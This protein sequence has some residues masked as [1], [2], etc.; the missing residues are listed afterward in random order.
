MESQNR[1]YRQKRYSFAKKGLRYFWQHKRLALLPTIGRLTYLITI[2]WLLMPLIEKA[3][4]HHGIT[5]KNAI[6]AYH[7]TL[8]LWVFYLIFILLLYINNV[9]ITFAYGLMTAIVVEEQKGNP[10]P[11]RSAWKICAKNF[12]PIMWWCIVRAVIGTGARML[13]LV[14]RTYVM[15][16]KKLIGGS[17]HDTVYFSNLLISLGKAS[18]Y[19]SIAASRELIIKTWGDNV[20]IRISPRLTIYTVIAYIIALTPIILAL[21][22]GGAGIFLY[23]GYLTV[24]LINF[25]QVFED[26]LGHICCALLYLYAAEDYAKAPFDKDEMTHIFI[27]RYSQ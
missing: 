3:A 14:F 9:L 15:L 21:H 5:L 2:T 12:G 18:A 16:R 27:A 4:E 6:V 8:S 1:T 23:G 13:L 26:T 24:I 25:I 22:H 10:H 7:H 19:R 20:V 11:W 17:W